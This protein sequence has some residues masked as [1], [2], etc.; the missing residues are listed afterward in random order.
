MS[1]M[2]CECG[3]TIFDQSDNLPYKGKI[4][5]DQDRSGLTQYLVTQIESFIEAI[6]LGKREKW[7]AERIDYKPASEVGND[8]VIEFL[9]SIMTATELDIFQCEACGNVMIET[10][11]LSNRFLSY[12]P[13]E[14]KGSSDGSVLR[15]T[16]RK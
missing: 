2:R 8:E 13:S 5:R 11:P 16:A 10:D 12:R 9:L 14:W 6:S 1:K 4:I 15:S 7:V 3:N